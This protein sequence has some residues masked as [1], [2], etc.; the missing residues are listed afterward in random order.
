[1]L[2]RPA[3]V[4]TFA[5]ENVAIVSLSRTAVESGDHL[6]IRCGTAAADVLFAHCSPANGHRAHD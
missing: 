6:T 1:M 4:A 5:M 3:N 2:L